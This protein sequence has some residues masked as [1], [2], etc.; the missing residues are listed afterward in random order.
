MSDAVDIAVVG[1]GASGIAA[2]LTASRMG[3]SVALIEAKHHCGGVAAYGLHRFV[4]GLFAND[5]DTPGQPLNPGITS[6]FCGRLAGG[7]IREKAIRR[8][9]VWLLPFNGGNAFSLCALDMLEREKN[10]KLLL[11]SRVDQLHVENGHIR[12]LTLSSMQELSARAVVDCTGN[13]AVSRLA[14]APTIGPEKPA[15]A[16]YGFTV[17][18]VRNDAADIPLSIQVPFALRQVADDGHIPRWLAFTTYEPTAQTGMATIKLAVPSDMSTEDARRNAQT[19]WDH[20]KTLPVFRRAT[21]TAF[22]PCVLERVGCR[23]SGKYMLT[24]DDILQGKTFDDDAVKGAWPMEKWDA[25]RGVS[26]RYPPHGVHYGIPLRC[27]HPLCGLTNLTCA[28]MC[29][30]ADDDAAAS[31]R[32]LGTCLATGEAAARLAVTKL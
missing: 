12:S 22:L 28:G 29:I 5:G 24:G 17:S 31:A 3:A 21:A 8:G 23:L 4:C 20:L 10:L 25:A 6:G 7:D 14:G 30:S 16:G 18:G 19:A 32:I 13:A 9:R 15:L 11:G 26:Y 1:A 2:A 27:L